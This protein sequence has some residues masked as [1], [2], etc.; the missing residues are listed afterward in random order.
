M[1]DVDRRRGRSGLRGDPARRLCAGNLAGAARRQRSI[2]SL[3]Q[4]VKSDAAL[5][6]KLAAEQKRITAARRARKSRDNAVAWILIAAASI[7]LTF[8]KRSVGQASLACAG[9]SAPLLPCGGAKAPRGLKPA[10]MKTSDFIDDLVANHGR[11][12]ENAISPPPG[13]PETLSLPP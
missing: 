2:K 1:L 5:A 3:Q 11:S 8:A 6:A 7:F 9:L 12:K 4:Q 10:P 13:H